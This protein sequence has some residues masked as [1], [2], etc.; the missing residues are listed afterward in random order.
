MSITILHGS[1]TGNAEEYARYLKLRLRYYNI[2]STLS[3]LDDY[4][5]K[6]LITE[7]KYL[8][9]ICS[10]TGQGEL[11]RNGKKFMKFILKKKLPFDLFQHINLSC[12]GIGDSSYTK[13]NYAI[14][15]IYTR[16]SQLGCN[17]LSPNC[18][19]DEMSPEGVDGYY[20]EWETQLLNNLLKIFPNEKTD[21]IPMPLTKLIKSDHESDIIPEENLNIGTIIENKRLTAEDHFQDVRLIKIKTDLPYEPG[22]SILL[23]PCNFDEDVDEL[24]KSQNWE[25]YANQPYKINNFNGTEYFVTLRNLIKYHLDIMSIP[26]RSFFALLYHFCDDSTADGQREKEKLQEFGDFNE[27]EDLYDYANRPRRSILEVLTEFQHIHIPISYVIDLIPRIKPRFFSIA[28]INQDEIEIIVAIV[29]YKT[30]IRRLRRGLCTRWLK[31]LVPGDL[32]FYKV[33]KSSFKYD[34]PPIIMVAPGTGVAPMKSLIEKLKGHEMYLFFGCRFKEKDYLIKDMFKDY[35]NLHIFT[36]FSRD[37]SKYVQDTLFSEYKL[38]GNLLEQGARIFVCG[39]SGKMPRE[40]KLTFIEIIKKYKQLTETEA[41][42]YVNRL[43][44]IGKYKEDCCL[45][46]PEDHPGRSKSDTYYFNK[47]TLLRTHTSA[48]EQECFQNCPTSGYLICADVYRKDEIDRTHYPA[49]HQL[50][51]ARVWNKGDLQRIQDDIHLIPETN[52]IVDDPFK[53][54]PVTENNPMQ[55]YMNEDEVRL[56]A[57]HLKKTINYIVHVVFEKARISAK[58]QGSKEPY[59][60][61]PLKVRWVEAYFPWTSPSWEIEVWWKGEWLESCGCGIVQQ[62]VLTNSGLTNKISWAF[63][64]GL[65]RLAMLLFD[66]PDIRLFWT[67]DERFHKQFSKDKISTFIPYSKFPGVKRDVSFWINDKEIHINDVMEIVRSFAG[68]MAESVTL[69]DKFVH[70]KT[71]KTSECYRINYQSMDRNLTNAEINEIHDKVVNNLKNRFNVE[72]R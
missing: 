10:T 63:G 36:S 9:I 65:D 72:I 34:D 37:E 45:G 51:G 27:P 52:I 56:V 61:E 58:L 14:K 47:D 59:L 6:N 23:Y 55:S 44:D 13:Y 54:K 68:D 25:N 24:I 22:D 46:F 38:I 43:E 42:S 64:I 1:E 30:I 4:P 71:K 8:I 15:K 50:E 7:T 53:D 66:I 32:I 57:T 69:I 40:V 48:H 29:E 28:S 20:K 41:T 19:A 62:Q 49:F 70:P 31:S 17:E 60:N 67:K 2:K 12:F 18:E 33:D 39:S 21:A 26:R 11:P 35:P 16:M 3:S 5:L